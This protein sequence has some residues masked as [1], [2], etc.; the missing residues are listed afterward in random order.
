METAYPTSPQLFFQDP[1]HGLVL[2]GPNIRNNAGGNADQARNIDPCLE[3]QALDH[4]DCPIHRKNRSIVIIKLAVNIAAALRLVKTL[5]RVRSVC[6]NRWLEAMPNR[7]WSV[8]ILERSDE[9]LFPETDQTIVFSGAGE[10]GFC[11]YSK[12]SSNIASSRVVDINDLLCFTERVPHPPN[13][14]NS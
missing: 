4:W 12:F 8:R 5:S 6:S 3:K 14:T 10:D 11:P 7:T 9:V 1:T 13:Q 2:S